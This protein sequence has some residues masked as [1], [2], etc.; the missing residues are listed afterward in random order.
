MS[1]ASPTSHL[2]IARRILLV[3]PIILHEI[4]RRAAGIVFMAVFVPVPGVAWRHAQIDRCGANRPA[5]DD[6]RFAVDQ[7][8]LRIG[9]ADVDA[10]IKIR[11][12]DIDRDA[13]AGKRRRGYQ[14]HDSR[15][16]KSF[17]C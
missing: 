17:H 11:F 4:D 16:Q 15:E 13:D 3:V 7:D 14:H 8:R 10:A 6:D 1:L 9:V 12:T 5:L 2:A